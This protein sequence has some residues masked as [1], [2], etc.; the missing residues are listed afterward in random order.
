VAVGQ[1][2][3]IAAITGTFLMWRLPTLPFYALRRDLEIV[4]Q[5]M[6]VPV[7][8][9]MLVY[10]SGAI[11]TVG[12]FPLL[13]NG[14]EYGGFGLGLG[15]AGAPLTLTLYDVITSSALLYLAPRWMVRKG[16]AR[17]GGGGR[18]E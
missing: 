4:L 15:F 3:S 13:M 16:A 18:S 17:G 10:A 8:P 12:L 5:C 1:P 9:R 7:L 2:A 6:Q 14:G 11:A